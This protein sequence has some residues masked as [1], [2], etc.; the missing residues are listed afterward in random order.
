MHTRPA[1]KL[2]M[3]I[4]QYKVNVEKSQNVFAVIKVLQIALG[5]SGLTGQ[6]THASSMDLFRITLCEIEND[7]DGRSLTAVTL[8][9]LFF[10]LVYSFYSSIVCFT[11]VVVIQ[12]L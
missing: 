6:K 7:D 10:N 12:I 4:F 5:T 9:S 1:K 3:R 8:F 11:F 2:K